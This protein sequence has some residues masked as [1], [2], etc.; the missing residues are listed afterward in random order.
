MNFPMAFQS[1]QTHLHFNLLK[2]ILL[3]FYSTCLFVHSRSLTRVLV[4]LVSI[5]LPDFR[6]FHY[7]N[8]TSDSLEKEF[9]KTI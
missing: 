6:C 9:K 8:V 7:E 3:A 5:A 2:N 4:R 1:F